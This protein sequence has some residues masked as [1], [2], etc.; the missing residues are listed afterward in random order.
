MADITKPPQN[1]I[2]FMSSAIRPARHGEN[3]V[4]WRPSSLPQTYC[5][6]SLD[7]ATNTRNAIRRR[8]RPSKPGVCRV[9]NAGT[10]GRQNTE[11]INPHCTSAARP[12]KFMVSMRNAATGQPLSRESFSLP[13]VPHAEANTNGGVTC[14]SPS[15]PK[16]SCRRTGFLSRMKVLQ[17][18]R[19]CQFRADA[20]RPRW[21][22]RRRLDREEEQLRSRQVYAA[23]TRFIPDGLLN[24]LTRGPGP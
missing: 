21:R 8:S 11:I 15:A 23:R 13:V 16:W 12:M 17:I 1:P 19:R 7:C 24:L 2:R 22:L 14:G 3:G 4:I 9:S 5:K 10:W 20:C 18:D 6:T